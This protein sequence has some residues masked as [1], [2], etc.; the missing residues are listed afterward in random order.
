M[1]DEEFLKY[2][3]GNVN[4]WL[5]WAEAKISALFAVDIAIIVAV[6]SLLNGEMFQ[7]IA[8]VKYAPIVISFICLFMSTGICLW[9]FWPKFDKISEN[10]N[11]LFFADIAKFS[12]GFTYLNYLNDKKDF[13]LQMYCDE[14]VVNSTISKKKYTKFKIGVGFTTC[15]LVGLFIFITMIIC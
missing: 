15:G 9:S 12:D 3:L 4:D 6:L 5:K 13:L 10:K 8:T 11:L 1:I 2:T 14:I 7:G